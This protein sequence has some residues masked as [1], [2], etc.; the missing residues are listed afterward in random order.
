MQRFLSI[1]LGLLIL[2]CARGAIAQVVT[3]ANQIAIN[4]TIPFP[5]VS[6]HIQDDFESIRLDGSS[7][8]ISFYDGTDYRG[9]LYMTE[10]N[11]YLF[12]R[13]DGGLYLGTRNATRL[14]VSPEGNVGIGTLDP[15]TKLQVNQGALG[16]GQ[17]NANTIG[18]FLKGSGRSHKKGEYNHPF[19]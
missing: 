14:L 3:K 10:N 6:L 12:N 11:M 15:Q 9:Y 17:F 2:V 4:T 16:S 8:F 19:G 1:A 5:N 13:K 18:G 7:P